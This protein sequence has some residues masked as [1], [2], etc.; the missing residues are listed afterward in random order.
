[1]P[2][3]YKIVEISARRQPALRKPSAPPLRRPLEP[4]V[5]WIGLKWSTN[6]AASREG[7]G[8]SGDHEDRFQDRALPGF[9]NRGSLVTP[10]L[11]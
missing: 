11:P 9:E 10:P 3:I 7:Q 1:M 6:A 4:S 5:T 8:I 2:D